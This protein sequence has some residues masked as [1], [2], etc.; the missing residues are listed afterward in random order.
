LIKAGVPA[1]SVRIVPGIAEDTRGEASIINDYAT[2]ERF[3]SM[4]IVTSSYHSRRALRALRNAGSGTGMVIGVEPAAEGSAHL[5]FWWLRPDGWRTV[6]VE[7]VK[8]INDWFKY[9]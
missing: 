4:L 3:R 8:L 7:F 2:K 9:E 6:G 5:L 1:N